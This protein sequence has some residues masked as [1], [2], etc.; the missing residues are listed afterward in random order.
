[1]NQRGKII[2]REYA[3][4]INDFTGLRY[5]SITPTDIDGFVEFQDKLYI[6]FEGKYKNSEMPYGQ[7]L[8]LERLCDS[9]GKGGKPCFLILASYT[10]FNKNGDIDFA[11]CQVINYRF[12]KKWRSP[13]KPITVRGVIDI[14][15]EYFIVEPF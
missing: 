6:I 7:R 15:Y 12:K 9:I 4:R 1:M 11:K 3:L 13:K 8:A 10:E 2:N 5:G 14:L